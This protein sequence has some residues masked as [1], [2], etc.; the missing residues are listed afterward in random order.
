[1]RIL[2]MATL[3]AV[4]VGCSSG[5]ASNS[6]GNSTMLEDQHPEQVRKVANIN[7]CSLLTDEEIAAQVDL[8]FEPDQRAALHEKSVK[9]QI[10]KEEDRTG[11][12]PVCR[13]TWR[14]I[15]ANGE[16]WATGNFE[17][18]VMP[19]AMFET[20][21]GTGPQTDSRPVRIDGVSGA[22]LYVE[23][24]PAARVGDVGISLTE[25][26]ATHEGNGGVELIKAA[27]RRLR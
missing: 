12:F 20:I 11:A 8:T 14:S 4:A 1:M 10:T 9:H 21:Q 3:F 15:D 6:G 22:Q 25:F 17:L 27:A 19:A 18:R 23:P 16:Q 24:Q 13:L 5:E 2:L 26:P 7:P